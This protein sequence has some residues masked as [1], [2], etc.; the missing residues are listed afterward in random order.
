M[1]GWDKTNTT[2]VI[3]NSFIRSQFCNVRH[4]RA[5]RDLFKTLLCMEQWI[6]LL[7]AKKADVTPTGV[8]PN[9][10]SPAKSAIRITIKKFVKTVNR[11]H[12]HGILAPN[13]RP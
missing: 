11:M 6:K 12:T 4:V 2:S 10:E 5:Y 9:S 3:D 7:S 8:G 1:I 13:G